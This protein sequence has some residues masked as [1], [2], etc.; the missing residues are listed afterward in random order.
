MILKE[1]YPPG[2]GGKKKKTGRIFYKNI[3]IYNVYCCKSIFLNRR[4]VNENFE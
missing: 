2:R 1:K 4:G 3:I